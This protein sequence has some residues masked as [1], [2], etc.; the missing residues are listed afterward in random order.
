MKNILLLFA[1]FTL[2]NSCKKEDVCRNC[3]IIV[4]ESFTLRLSEGYSSPVD[5]GYS[6]S[7][8]FK[9]LEVCTD[10]HWDKLMEQKDKFTLQCD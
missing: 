7:S 6:E 3:E 10:E 1:L 9:Q 4:N 2:F 5:V 8:S